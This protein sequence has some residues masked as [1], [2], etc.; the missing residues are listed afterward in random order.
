[1]IKDGNE[2]LPSKHIAFGNVLYINTKITKV[3]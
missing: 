3:K 1:M 2:N